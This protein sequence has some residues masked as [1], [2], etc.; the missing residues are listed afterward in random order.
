LGSLA[1]YLAHHRGRDRAVAWI[2]RSTALDRPALWSKLRGSGW[3]VSP[4]EPAVG[5][6]VSIEPP[7]GDRFSGSALVA[8]PDR[9]LAATVGELG[10]GLFRLE[11]WSHG[12]ETALL[13]E[14]A[15]WQAGAASAIAALEARLG[16]AVDRALAA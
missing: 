13:L 8:H 1:H 3:N 14:V 16:A 12:A 2:S 4:P 10:N 6:A 7:T 5:R 15:S 11:T 9:Q